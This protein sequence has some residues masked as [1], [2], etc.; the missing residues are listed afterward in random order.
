LGVGASIVTVGAEGA[1]LVGPA[2]ALHVP[3][4]RVSVVDTVGA[5]DAFNGALGTLLAGGAA[6]GDALAVA[7]AAGALTCARPGAMDGL[8]A[9]EEVRALREREGRRVRW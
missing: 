4:F 6:I 9:R 8:P 2:G 1:V 3:G 5:G 7:N